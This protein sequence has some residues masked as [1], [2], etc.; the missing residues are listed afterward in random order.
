MTLIKPARI[1]IPVKVTHNI[2]WVGVV[3][4][5]GLHTSNQVLFVSTFTKPL[6]TP[7]FVKRT[8]MLSNR[9]LS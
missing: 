2:C 1:A 8:I 9:R 5:T 6:E 7:I 3:L 4:F